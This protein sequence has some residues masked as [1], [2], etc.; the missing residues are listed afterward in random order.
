METDGFAVLEEAAR[1]AAAEERAAK[2]LNASVVR[3]IASRS[4]KVAFFANLACRL[5]RTPAWDLDTGSTDGRR[6]KYNPDFV[7]GL[8][9]AKL[10][11]FIAHE[12]MHCGLLHPFRLG[13]RDPKVFNVA[14]DC[15]IN[16]ILLDAGM[17]LP[18]GGCVPG[19]GQYAHL[20]KGLSAE[21][22]YELLRRPKG[23]QQDKDD[24]P[25]GGDGEGEGDGDQDGDGPPPAGPADPGG[26]GG[27][28]APPSPAEARQ[29][30]ADWRTAV[31][32]A[33]EAAKGRGD[34]GGGIE[35]LVGRA[36]KPPV[37]W[38]EAL[39]DFVS[40]KAK[41]RRSW[42]KVSRRHLSL[43]MYL[44]G[45]FSRELGDVLVMADMSGSTE[46][47]LE[48]FSAALADVL[49]EFECTATVVYHDVPVQKVTTFDPGDGEEFAL[50]PVGG[51]GTSHV[52]VFTWLAEQ[53]EQPTCVIALTDLDSVF[54]N[55][56]DV[57]VLWAVAGNPGASGPFGDTVHLTT[58]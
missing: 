56:P 45:K 12:V 17:E 36:A 11:G 14:A 29:G 37:D 10:D 1:R 20:P 18:D 16:D 50:E 49:E 9:P 30:E 27:V 34:L 15:S 48:V 54:P 43:G 53:D 46:L 2:A 19:K 24:S 38:R 58:Y 47:Y 52:E 42:N 35:S 7:A 21:E 51:G 39:R 33:A 57:P 23:G 26:N 55:P 25:G 31:V 13:A 8:S 5:E 22:Y 3:L 40:Q 6:L 41:N 44:P 4:A 32:M 28:E